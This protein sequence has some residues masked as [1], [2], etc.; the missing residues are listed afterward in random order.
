MPGLLVACNLYTAMLG[1]CMQDHVQDT[2]KSKEGLLFA[3]PQDS[4]GKPSC[5]VDTLQK[6]MHCCIV[7]RAQLLAVASAMQKDIRN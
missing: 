2:T 7:L 4:R 3:S 6:D 5:Y 1:Y